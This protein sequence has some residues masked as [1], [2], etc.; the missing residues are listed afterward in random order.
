VAFCSNCG[1]ALSP[2]ASICPQCGTPTAGATAQ[3][4]ATPAVAA[5]A[6]G[7]LEGFA[8][9]SLLCGLGAFFIIPVVGSILAIVFGHIGTARVLADP[10]FRGKELARAGIIIGW[11]GIVLAVIAALLIIFFLFII[12]DIFK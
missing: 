6:G 12:G 7:Q 9:A 5:P 3:A 4:Q 11:V 8:V 2:Q 10:T 1:R